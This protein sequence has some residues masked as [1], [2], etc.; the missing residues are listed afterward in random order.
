MPATVVDPD[1]IRSFPDPAA[2]SAWLAENHATADA[3]WVRIYKKSAGI[4]SITWEQLVLE[5]LCWGWIDGISKRW[6]EHSYVQRITPR[7]AQSVWSQRNCEHVERLIAAGRMQP[8]GLAAVEAAK[9]DG[10]W[11]KA[12]A[13]PSTMTLP[14]DFLA[15]VA[16]R[17]AAEAFLQTLNKQ[18]RYA[19]AY[20]LHSPKKPE[21]RQRRMEQIL[22]MLER[23]ERFH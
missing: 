9:A 11:D 19:I 12:Y 23:G 7:R 3:L 21:T 20:R 5:V 1:A 16:E 6:D 22:A 13:P 4:P 10:R 18:N 17:P 15:A 2:L 14:D 8:S